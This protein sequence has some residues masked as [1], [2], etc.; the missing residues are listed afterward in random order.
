MKKIRWDFVGMLGGIAGVLLAVIAVLRSGSPN[1]VPIAFAMIIVFG[2]M[3]LLLYKLLWQPRFNI[4]RLTK[5]GISS[6][7]KILEVH[8]TNIAVNN[9]PQVKLILELT[10]TNG[11]V[12]NTSCKTIVS[13][14]NPLIFQP[15]NEVKV[16]VD[17]ANEN[18]V[19][20]DVS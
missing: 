19:I 20:I 13:R 8:D 4:K 2:G 10:N 16:K 12:Y 15:G 5:T 14:K 3:G 7:A 17:P 6:R 11:Q 9:N 1:K 18:N